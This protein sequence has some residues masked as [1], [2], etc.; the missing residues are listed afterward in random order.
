MLTHDKRTKKDTEIDFVL[1]KLLP[2]TPKDELKIEDAAKSEIEH[3]VH[4]K[5]KGYDVVKAEKA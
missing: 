5:L 4:R 2:D 3:E 1:E